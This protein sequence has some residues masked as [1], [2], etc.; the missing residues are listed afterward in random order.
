MIPLDF[1]FFFFFY[2]F[3]P[4]LQ[5]PSSPLM[6]FFFSLFHFYLLMRTDAGFALFIFYSTCVA[7]F[8]FSFPLIFP[9]VL[10][11]DSFAFGPTQPWHDILIDVGPPLN[12]LASVRT[13]IKV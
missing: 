7:D 3:L 10:S 4:A 6:S 11:Q 5:I 9:T 2:F 8:F 12:R 1:T 13:R